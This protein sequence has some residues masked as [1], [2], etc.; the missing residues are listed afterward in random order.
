MDTTGPNLFNQLYNIGSDSALKAAMQHPDWDAGFDAALRFDELPFR[1]KDV[2][3]MVLL[4]YLIVDLGCEF[5]VDEDGRLACES[6]YESCVWSD[7]M[8]VTVD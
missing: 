2:S 6:Q 7:G 5:S 8:W 1:Q 4:A 3:D